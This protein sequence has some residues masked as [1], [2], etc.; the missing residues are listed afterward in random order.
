LASWDSPPTDVE[1]KEVSPLLDR[2]QALKRGRGGALSGI[3]LMAF[4]CTT[5]GSASAASSLQALELLWLGGFFSSL[6]K[7]N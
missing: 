1:R 7:V 3:Q 5:S 4:F 2:I 6:W